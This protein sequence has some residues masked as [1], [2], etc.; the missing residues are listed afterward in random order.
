MSIY[1]GR[2]YG[3]CIKMDECTYLHHALRWDGYYIRPE[4]VRD[5]VL[6]ISEFCRRCILKCRAR[7]R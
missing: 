7:V 1:I 4:I 3:E 5:L 6:R 2:D